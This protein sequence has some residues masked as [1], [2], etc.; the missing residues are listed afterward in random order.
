MMQ[1]MKTYALE[2]AQ[3]QKNE[4]LENEKIWQTVGEIQAA[5]STATGSTQEIN[6]TRRIQSTHTALT[7]NRDVRPGDR[8]GGYSVDY[9]IQGRRYN[10]LFLTRED[11]T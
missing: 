10:Q 11:K 3:A 6:Q 7:L 1:R 2:R 9:A 4:L 5:I 8:F